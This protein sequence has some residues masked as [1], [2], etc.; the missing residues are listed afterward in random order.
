V[1]TTLSACALYKNHRILPTRTPLF[2]L[3]GLYVFAYPLDNPPFGRFNLMHC[4]PNG[5]TLNYCNHLSTAWIIESIAFM[6]MHR[7]EPDDL[8]YR[9][10]SYKRS[11]CHSS[12]P[13]NRKTSLKPVRAFI[14]S[15]FI[16]F[17]LYYVALATNFSSTRTN[18]IEI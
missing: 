9:L 10:A 17:H 2:S 14:P 12:F 8:S 15:F 3:G 5:L 16:H 7:I 6:V 13:L 18:V 4:L 11:I 1:S